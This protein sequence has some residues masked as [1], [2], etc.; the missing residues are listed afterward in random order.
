[1][2]VKLPTTRDWHPAYRDTAFFDGPAMRLWTQPY[3]SHLNK[4]PPSAW[5][6]P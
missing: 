6:V 5:L 2:P 4:P 3:R 1:M